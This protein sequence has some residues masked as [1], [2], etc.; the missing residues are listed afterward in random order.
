LLLQ[1]IYNRL[2]A[3]C[4]PFRAAS[5]KKEDTRVLALTPLI[6]LQNSFTVRFG[7]KFAVKW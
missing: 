2:L 1:S 5:K 6:S 3:Y 7:S 4:S